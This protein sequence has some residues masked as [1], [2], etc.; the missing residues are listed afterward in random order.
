MTLSELAVDMAA[1][2]VGVREVT[3]NSGPEI[4]EWLR[5]VGQP[6]GQPWC[7]AFVFA[8]FAKAAGKLGLW[9]PVPRTA[10]SQRMWRHAEPICRDSNP[11]PGYV[12]VLRHSETTGHVGIVED[13][14]ANGV[15]TEISGNTFTAGGGRAGDSVARHR[16]QPEVTHGGVLLGYLDFDRA[17]QPPP[18]FVA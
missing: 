5:M 13:V 14:D 12:Y 17:A 2:A 10:S 9:N 15:I 3:R 7:A 8:V 16:G 18:G 4:D 6:P 1:L 11:K